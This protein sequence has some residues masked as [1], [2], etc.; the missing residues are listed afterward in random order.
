MIVGP[1]TLKLRTV[2]LSDETTMTR[3]FLFL[4]VLRDRVQVRTTFA[5]TPKKLYVDLRDRVDCFWH[6][7]NV[8][9]SVD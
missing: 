7:D 5:S 4:N 1:G 9:L 2:S 3:D 8:F 6:P